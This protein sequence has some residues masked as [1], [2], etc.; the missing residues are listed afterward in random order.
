MEN[1]EKT[2][3]REET[4][5]FKPT[6]VID[7]TGIILGRLASYAAKQALL[8]KVIAIVNCNDIAVSGNKDNIIF[9]YQRLRKLDKSNQKGPIFP[10]V[11]EKITKR[12]IRGML[13][14]KQQR[15]EKALDRVRC[16]NSIPAELVSAKKITLKDFSIESKE[17]KSLTLKEI[18]KLI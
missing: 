12:T 11:A 9:E 14:Y 1:K 2:Q 10:K 16:Y 13:S 4:K 6:L 18:A 5:E 15:G 7:G 17:V 3:E 8:G